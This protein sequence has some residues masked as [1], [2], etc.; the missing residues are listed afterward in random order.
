MAA[1]SNTCQVGLKAHVA[2]LVQNQPQEVQ[3][4]FR[5]PAN[6]LFSHLNIHVS[7]YALGYFIHSSPQIKPTEWWLPFPQSTPQ[8]I[9]GRNPKVRFPFRG[10]LRE[11]NPNKSHCQI[12]SQAATHAAFRIFVLS[13]PGCV[14]LARK[15]GVLFQFKA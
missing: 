6:L 7:R 4:T 13:P 8:Q 14:S 3:T 9:H 10:K 12:D 2:S 5:L 1:E 11:P 15:T